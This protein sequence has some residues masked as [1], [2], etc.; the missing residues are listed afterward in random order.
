MPRSIAAGRKASGMLRRRTG[1]GYGYGGKPVV[2]TGD[3]AWRHQFGTLNYAI[4]WCQKYS[5]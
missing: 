5:R 1:S 3:A 2:T 4:A